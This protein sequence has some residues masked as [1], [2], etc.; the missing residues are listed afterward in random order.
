MRIQNPALLTIAVLLLLF[1]A[2]VKVEREPAAP[3][4]PA[5]ALPPEIEA[6]AALAKDLVSHEVLFKK[7][8]KEPLPLASLTKIISALVVLEQMGL[9][10]EVV[11][12]KDAV[13]APEPSSLRV[14]EHFRAGDLLSMV[15]VES[16]N[17]AITA[18]ALRAIQESGASYELFLDLMRRKAA[19]LGANGMNFY[20]ISGLD[21]SESV[22]GA[23][24]SAE[25]LMKIAEA[26]LASPLWGFGEAREIISREGIKHTLKPTNNLAPELMPL[27]GSKTGYTDLAGGNLLVI[28]EY[29]I[30]NPLGIVV[31]GSTEKGRFEDVKKIL[32][33]VKAKNPL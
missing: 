8:E 32:E 21:I 2:F 18:L 3:A 9:D 5:R 31:L 23:Y 17:D 12:S 15:M 6:R 11:I 10:E 30:G 4:V 16:S 26:S 25:D 20:N 24:G 7:N 1:S 28:V 29:P 14:G 33:W 13:L 19:S 22:S 27:L